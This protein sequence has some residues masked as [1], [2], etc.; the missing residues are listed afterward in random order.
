MKKTSLTPKREDWP[1]LLAGL[2]LC[3][4]F[5]LLAFVR[6]SFLVSLEYKIYDAMLIGMDPV[7]PT[8][9]PVIVDVDE[10]SLESFGQWPW[11]RSRVA[12]LLA[13]INEMQ[14]MSVGLDFFFP[15]ADGTSLDAV[16]ERVEK[17]F[18]Q[19]L[20][21]SEL[22]PEVCNNDI[23]LARVLKEGPFVLG[24]AFLFDRENKRRCSPSPESIMI[25]R[26]PDASD[27]GGF[28]FRPNGVA[29]NLEMFIEAAQAGGFANMAADEDGM[30]RRVPVVLEYQGKVY[31]SLALASLLKA[32]RPAIVML[33]IGKYG[34]ESLRID[35]RIVKLDEYGRLPIKFRGPGRT[36]EYLSA[37][38]LL[39]GKIEPERLHNRIVILGT[40]AAGLQDIHATPIDPA[41][42]G[43]EV[44]ATLLDNLIQNDTLSRPQWAPG[45]EIALT[46]LCG[47]VSLL[48]LTR[49]RVSLGIGCLV[50]GGMLLTWICQFRFHQTGVFISPLFPLLILT[51]DSILLSL[52]RYWQQDRLAREKEKKVMRMQAA[53]IETIANVTETRD[54]ETGGH[55][56]RTREYL[57]VLG[58]ELRN[59]PDF[60]EHISQESLD[61]LYQFA[62]LHDVGKVGVQDRVLLK[63]G[64]LTDEEYQEIKRHVNY[65]IGILQHAGKVMGN[66]S[67]LQLALDVVSGH[68]ERWDGLGYPEGLKAREIPWAGRLMAV[69]D[70]YDALISPRVYKKPMTHEKTLEII[71]NGSGT[72][73]DPAVVQAFLVKNEK[74]REIAVYFADTPSKQGEPDC[75]AN[76]ELR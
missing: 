17:E 40:S 63:E 60:K 13:V 75:Y 46:F 34:I 1:V 39:L 15:E 16:A 37:Q 67:Y 14:P 57:L 55:I 65:G 29:G 2:V 19:R 10:A 33:T 20:D 26:R 21:L 41:M 62:P 27:D 43:V 28:I 49:F 9:I 18:N 71:K 4:V 45:L 51:S 56:R 8:R 5:T 72:Q 64:R 32:I 23:L 22:P 24:Y 42:S 58:N 61:M 73:F 76:A 47:L 25:L 53:A 66:P 48:L 36:F 69:A 31:P 35:S 7:P 59:H 6:P 74:F 38:D 68:H 11:P 54:P 12:R 50:G 52:G 3:F 44:H 30:L 70:V